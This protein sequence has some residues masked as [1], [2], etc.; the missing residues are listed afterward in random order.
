[1]GF[2]FP[3]FQKLNKKRQVYDLYVTALGF[4]DRSLGSNEKI[5]QSG[6]RSRYSII[7]KY[8]ENKKSNEKDIIKFENT[9]QQIAGVYD[10][11]QYSFTNRSK[12]EKGFIKAINKNKIKTDLVAINIT[13][14]T[15][16]ALA[17]TLN[18][19]FNTF[20]TVK[21]IYTSP[22]KY[23]LQKDNKRNF[24]SGVKDIFT[25]PQFNGANLPG[26][27]TLLIILLGYDL[28]RARGIISEIQP[29]KKIGIIPK[30]TTA[31][32]NNEYQKN[33]SEHKNS[34]DY[35]DGF[36]KLSI[37][38]SKQ[39]F[40]KLTE[41]RLDH[42]ENHNILLALNGSKLHAIIALLFSMKYRDIQLIFSTPIEY[43]PEHYSKGTGSTFELTITKE[44]LEKFFKIH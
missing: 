37:F 28:I 41:I 17:W 23:Y 18:Y 32:M 44:W 34:F 4:E 6:I 7:L 19:L 30:P 22:K 8:N 33:R 5:L 11:S 26:Y 38:E 43:F 25:M 14:F 16:H 42:I 24:A 9:I 10:Y 13:S 12:F 3:I 31:N 36:E 29:S 40:K 35:N 1:M 39:L 21:I 27:R 20:Q 15:T 2:K